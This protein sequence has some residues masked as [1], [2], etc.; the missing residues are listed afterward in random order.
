[1]THIV[2]ISGSLD[3]DGGPA[4]VRALKDSASSWR[5]CSGNTSPGSTADSRRS[6]SGLER[7]MNRQA[8]GR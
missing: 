8:L 4:P 1:M 5:R 2:G 7:S 6:P 3:V